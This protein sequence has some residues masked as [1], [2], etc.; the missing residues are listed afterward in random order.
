MGKNEDY[1]LAATSFKSEIAESG[2]AATE[3][4]SGQPLLDWMT[5]QFGT[6]EM[7]QSTL[8]LIQ[9]GRDLESFDFCL[10]PVLV[11]MVAK[12]LSDVRGLCDSEMGRLRDSVASSLYDNIQS[13][14]RLQRLWEQLKS[15]DV[16]VS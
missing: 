1:K 16:R 10:E 11:S 8:S 2:D 14:E 7:Q 5:N 13:R 3:I 12:I 9:L 15:S 6:A 4:A